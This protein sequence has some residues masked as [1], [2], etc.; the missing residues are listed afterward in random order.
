MKL[1]L[2]P[3]VVALFGACGSDSTSARKSGLGENCQKTD[4]CDAALIC[5]YFVCSLPAA[6]Q[7]VYDEPPIIPG[8][9]VPVLDVAY[10]E[11]GPHGT[12]QWGLDPG[13]Q[14]PGG[15]DVVNPFD[16][17]LVELYYELGGGGDVPPQDQVPGIDL[18]AVCIEGSEV[19]GK[20][21]GM[22][23]GS[24]TTA[25]GD[26]PELEGTLAFEI[27]CQNTKLMVKGSMDGMGHNV[28]YPDAPFTATILGTYHPGTKTFGSEILDGDVNAYGVHVKFVG[29]LDGTLDAGVFD[30]TWT[31]HST[32][33]PLLNATGSGTWK[34]G[35]TLQ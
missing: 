35:M 16:A 23:D 24:I 34:A 20:W 9:D 3:V 2:L 12:D 15:D 28:G 19:V 21:V 32:D 5:R 7:D 13:Q 4:D 33:P 10:G 31:A 27:F 25:I 6:P 22:F 14:D 30:G 17:N 18:F 26:V 29:E 1:V 11:D 8:L